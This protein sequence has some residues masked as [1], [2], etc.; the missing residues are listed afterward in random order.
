MTRIDRPGVLAIALVA[1]V[2]AGA[3]V[4]TEGTSVRPH[5]AGATVGGATTVGIPA[6]ASIDP[7]NAFEPSSELVV[8]TICDTLV[9]TD[10]A[11]GELVPALAESWAVR[12][13]GTRF[14][15]RLRDDVT[16]HDGRP[17][18]ARDVAYSLN[19]LADPDVA[20]PA[21]ALLDEVA[22]YG[23]FRGTVEATDELN[24]Q[25][26]RGVRE[27]SGNAV[28]IFLAA[29]NA[30]WLA[31]LTHPAT[32]PV[33][34]DAAEADAEAFR[35]QPV[36]AGPY[37]V[38]APWEPGT[39]TI[40]V[41]RFADYHAQHGGFSGGGAGYLDDITFQTL[42]DSGQA[43]EP[44]KEPD[45]D[46]TT[47]KAP[48]IAP[49]ELDDLDVVAIPAWRW[50]EFRARPGV[51]VATATGPGVD[52]VGVVLASLSGGDEQVDRAQRAD[53]QLRLRRALSLALDRTAIAEEVF[54][55]G[56]VPATSMVP[57][58]ATGSELPCQWLPAEPDPVLARKLI[59]EA[60]VAFG[61]DTLEL[62][63]STDFANAAMAEAI[64]AQWRDVLGVDVQP[65]GVPFP[66]FVQTMETSAGSVGAF[67]TSWSVPVP[68]RRAYLF[69]LFH[70]SQIGQG[71]LQQYADFRFDELLT[72]DA[73]RADDATDRTLLL[74]EAEAM[75]CDQ[76]PLLPVVQQ[77]LGW[78][79]SGL[80]SATGT[81]AGGHAGRVLLR[82]L[83]HP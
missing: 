43:P 55:G 72:E 80:E 40:E 54:D 45:D 53:Q 35:G 37:R 19:R 10:P 57:S 78:A 33:S 68:S 70:S 79:V 16:F 25:R 30:D 26:L 7:V 75:I 41:E 32:A 71:N 81:I 13:D 76:V 24:R 38:A 64:A 8:D 82:E 65:R 62:L 42:Q 29:P 61:S 3:C 17:V 18:T 77:R 14:L 58:S 56:R 4:P 44:P 1:A 46:A 28:E 74:D 39:P 51:T 23:Q 36:C 20:S 52:Y 63:H 59:G 67:R 6:P 11:T 83:H 5:T 66:E 34:R 69:D 48:L 60:D 50:D 27:T 9:G 22:G 49:P 31:T 21:A 47:A 12:G 15:L 73:S 2:V